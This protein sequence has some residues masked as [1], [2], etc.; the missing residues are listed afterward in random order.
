MSTYFGLCK[1]IKAD[2]LFDGRLEAFG[3]REEVRPEGTAD[4]YPPY[5]KVKEVRYLTD[6]Q[7]SME[8]VIYEN[9][10][11]CINVRNFWCAPERE[12]LHAIAEAFETDIVSEHQPE[13]WGFDT[14]EE[15]DADEKR[16]HEEHERQ[17]HAKLLKHL[18]GEPTDIQPGT[19]GMMKAEIAKN[20]VEKDP[21]FMETAN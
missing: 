3:V 17:F 12:I 5:I 19:I 15:W 4:R 18:R 7:N 13:Y 9:G 16:I 6:G 10:V 21:S 14:Q 8:V 2:E 11:A 20:L 1:S